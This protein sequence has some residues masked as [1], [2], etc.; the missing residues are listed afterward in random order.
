MTCAQPLENLDDQI[1]PALVWL[2]RALRIK[3]A[4]LQSTL[5]AI[6][7]YA[8]QTIEP[9][10]HAGLILVLKGRL[11]PQ[12]T[13]GAPPHVLDLLQQTTGTGP[14]IEAAREQ[15][16]IGI[17][18]TLTDP[19]WPQFGAQ[20]AE[21]GVASMLCVPLW[22][23]DLRL[24]TLSLY[25]HKPDAFA[26]QHR[27]LTNLYAAFAA[28]ALADAQRTAQLQHALRNRD[29]IGQAKGIL[30]ERMRITSEEAFACLS[31]ASQHVNLKL[32]AV[33]QHLIDTGELL[34]S[35]HA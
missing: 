20:A 12:A 8:V 24:G 31:Q 22:V 29:L 30:V 9:A 16:V 14:C 11:V 7:A 33:A 2:A 17:G 21:L 3:D 34:D 26:P 18:H 13:L 27:E 32:T 10:E 5:D 35:F 19:R 15:E 6:I 25:G 4:E 28:I 23:D 1:G